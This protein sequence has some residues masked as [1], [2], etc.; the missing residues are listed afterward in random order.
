MTQM[1]VNPDDEDIRPDL[2]KAPHCYF[3]NCPNMVYK[4]SGIFCFRHFNFVVLP[5]VLQAV[6]YTGE[7]IPADRVPAEIAEAYK[8]EFRQAWSD[9]RHAAQTVHQDEG[10]TQ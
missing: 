10:S 4:Q 2:P 8:A 3:M 9:L 6:S 5:D 7:W 1:H